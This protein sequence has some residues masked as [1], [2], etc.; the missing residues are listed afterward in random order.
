MSG[1]GDGSDQFRSLDKGES[2]LFDSVRQIPASNVLRN[3]VAPPIV[4]AAQVVGSHDVGM[5]E[6]GDDAGLGEIRLDIAG[7]GDLLRV[8]HLDRYE[9]IEVVVSGQINPS[10]AAL[11]ESSN[12][13]VAPMASGSP[14]GGPS[15]GL[16]SGSSRS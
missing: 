9:A 8:G 7:T 10:E 13:R 16:S 6:P 14:W 2:I 15:S 11:T 4:G 3:D 1:P 5:V 12:D